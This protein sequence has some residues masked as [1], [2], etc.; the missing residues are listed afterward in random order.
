MNVDVWGLLGQGFATAV[1]WENLL[2]TLLG[3]LIGTVVGVLPGLGSITA[4]ALL[5]PVTF[6]LSPLSGLVMLCGVYFGSQYGSS[7]T[8]IL[9]RTPGDLGSVVTA[10]DGHEMA[11]QGRAGPALMT[12]A[13]GSFVAGTIAIIGLTF[14]APFFGK[15]AVALG[16]AELFL[17]MLLALLLVST[18]TTGST[19]KAVV[20]VLVGLAITTVGIDPVSGVSRNTFGSLDVYGGVDFVLIAIALFAIAEALIQLSKRPGDGLKSQAIGRITMTK[21]DWR[22]S[23]P[24]WGRGSAV[25]F[26]TGVLPGSGGTLAT[27]LS[28][29]LESKVI[30]KK[31]RK[32]F[33][34]GAIEAVA[35]PES[36]NN[37]AAVGSLVPLFTLGVPGSATAALLLLVFTMY[38]LQPGPG[39]Y[40]S[41][42][43]LI[44]GIIASLYLGNVALL[45][46][47]LPMV[48]VF[49]KLL[50]TP[51]A[52]LYTGVIGCAALGVIT[53]RTNQFDM[54]LM[55]I[56][57]VIGFFMAKYDFPPVTLILALVLGPMM[58]SS[59]ARALSSSGGDY[60]VFV[61][62]PIS[63]A[64]VI[65]A[66]L[67]AVLPPIGRAVL[68]RNAARRTLAAR[69]LVKEDAA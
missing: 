12:A 65:V 18:L 62:R 28:Y 6:G 59:F 36:A 60:L 69:S 55:V 49:A 17:I 25:G 29:M 46:L 41:Q 1:T 22:R 5:I 10:L 66:V 24:A 7:T 3:V 14:F 26:L 8:A 9:V 53:L 67:V 68:R 31:Y 15:F 57:G 51:P 13:V 37:G 21:E 43:P 38:G 4:V 27:F 2:F 63:L 11:R 54:I 40:E 34:R 35:G 45:V 16:A 61:E 48:G 52:L 58:E 56:V 30:P 19:L 23:A 42:G 33:G 32:Q 20:G 64:I 39:M 50:K 44:F 47:N